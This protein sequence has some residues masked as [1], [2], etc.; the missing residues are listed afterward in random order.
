MLRHSTGYKLANDGH[1]TRSLAHYLGP[2]KLAEH[3][4]IY[5]VSARSVREVLGGLTKRRGWSRAQP[6]RPAPTLT[7]AHWGCRGRLTISGEA[8]TKLN[9]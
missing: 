2:S 3:G 7:S 5:S 4:E 8:Y 1:D 6:Q 9:E